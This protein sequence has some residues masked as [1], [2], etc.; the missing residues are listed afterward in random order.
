MQTATSHRLRSTHV[1]PSEPSAPRPVSVTVQI[2]PAFCFVV[3]YFRTETVRHSHAWHKQS[4]QPLRF[5]R[6]FAMP[7]G[8][9]VRCYSHDHITTLSLRKTKIVY[10]RS[11]A[12]VWASSSPATGCMCAFF[13]SEVLVVPQ[14]ISIH[15][16]T[17]WP[18]VAFG[19]I[20]A[21]M[22][23]FLARRFPFSIILNCHAKARSWKQA[24][25]CQKKSHTNISGKS[26][27]QKSFCA[28][29][30]QCRAP[31]MWSAQNLIT[32]LKIWFCYT[33][34]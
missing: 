17:S 16:L 20:P 18:I 34:V 5:G 8:T 12:C 9:A 14:P 33:K 24:P 6:S 21:L 13:V 29:Y 15:V 25:G 27:I 4:C 32:T 2:L 7:K 31:S 28:L 23:H 26:I 11:H 22:R 10:F 1:G 3:W 30:N 19:S